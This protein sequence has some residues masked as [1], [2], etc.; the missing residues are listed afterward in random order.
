MWKN[1]DKICWTLIDNGSEDKKVKGAKSVIKREFKFEN[2][3][4]YLK[5]TQ[6]GDKIKYLEKNK[7]NINQY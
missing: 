1:Y 7:I 2:Y 5:E 4:N 6:L 3:E